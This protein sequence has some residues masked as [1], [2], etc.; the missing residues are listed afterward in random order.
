MELNSRREK[1]REEDSRNGTGA[2]GV[3]IMA[4]ER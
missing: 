1:R 2:G 4:I 3:P